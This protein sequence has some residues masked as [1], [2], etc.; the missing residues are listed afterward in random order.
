MQVLSPADYDF[1]AENGYVI[2]HDA[3][4]QSNLDAVIDA[5]WTFLGIDRNDPED[6][7]R[8]PLRAN[9][10]V[11]M[12]QHQSLWDNRQEPRATTR[13]LTTPNTKRSWW[14]FKIPVDIT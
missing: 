10:M 11:E 12:Y 9:G 1:F 13:P 8:E 7:Y 4:P 14:L 5:I 3:V 2:V 6:W